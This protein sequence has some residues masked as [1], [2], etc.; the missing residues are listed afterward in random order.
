MSFVQVPLTFEEHPV[1]GRYTMNSLRLMTKEKVRT[2][3][4]NDYLTTGMSFGELSLLIQE[5]IFIHCFC[6]TTVQVLFFLHFD[7]AVCVVD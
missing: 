4:M 3:E 1:R 5:E 2:F 7:L 6:D